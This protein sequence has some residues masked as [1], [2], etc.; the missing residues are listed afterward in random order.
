[1]L[2][3]YLVLAASGG[4]VNGQRLAIGATVQLTDAEAEYEVDLGNVR[5]VGD[6]APVVPAILQP[7]DKLSVLRGLAEHPVTAAEM[8]AYL[9]A[10]GRPVRSA[11]DAA[12]AS[13]GGST[14]PAIPPIVAAIIFG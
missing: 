8:E 4:W 10:A 7:G 5:L 11:I 12:A 14:G 2:R 13:G 6:A 1:M 9:L 3:D